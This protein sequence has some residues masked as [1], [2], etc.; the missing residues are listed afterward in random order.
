MAELS[1]S[2]LRSLA[3]SSQRFADDLQD[4]LLPTTLPVVPGLDLAGRHIPARG[5][6]GLLGDFYDVF[7]SPLGCWHVVIGDVCGHGIQAAKLTALARWSIQTAATFTSDPVRI[8]E[9]LHGLIL[10]HDPEEFV[11]AQ[12][13]T[14]GLGEAGRLTIDLAVAGHPTGLLRRA[15]GSVELCGAGGSVLGIVEGPTVG[16]M[17]AALAVGDHLVL[18]TDGLYEGR[19]RGEPLGPDRVQQRLATTAGMGADTTAT[20]LVDLANDWNGGAPND[21]LALIIVG[22]SAPS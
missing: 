20:A 5:E 3:Q 18:Y 12:L 16:R 7:H 21:D 9:T 4:S 22:P 15:D 17:R 14:L 19:L 11:S 8:L 10:R 13:L 2:N 6:A 1:T